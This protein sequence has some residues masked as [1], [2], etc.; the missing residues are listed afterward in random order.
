MKDTKTKI[1]Q[2]MDY[3][4]VNNFGSFLK[5]DPF[6]NLI[7]GKNFITI[8]AREAISGKSYL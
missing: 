7:F 4:K 8:Q 3:Q 6:F 1:W 5:K 2:S